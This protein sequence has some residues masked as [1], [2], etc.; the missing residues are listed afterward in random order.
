MLSVKNF[1]L[2]CGLMWGGGLFVISLTQLMWPWY[3]VAFLSIMESIYPGYQGM[4]GLLGALVL[5]LYGLLD[6][7]V[8]GGI[9][10]WLY[11][12]LNS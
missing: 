2:T 4:E 1:A 11:N 3:G 10:A 12:R 5:L 6:G 9:F 7:I 8:A